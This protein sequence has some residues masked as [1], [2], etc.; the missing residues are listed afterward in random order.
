MARI[1]SIRLGGEY[2]GNFA[3]D[4][5]PVLL[6]GILR[7][8]LTGRLDVAFNSDEQN[9]VYFR[10]GVPIC[11]R[12]PDIGVSLADILI[13]AG[14]V[15]H[16]SGLSVQREAK[17]KHQSE[18]VV[19]AA[20]DLCPEG[21]LFSG[22][23]VRARSELVGLFNVGHRDFRFIEGKE[24]PASAEL[25]I[26]Q[27]L[28]LIYE[29]LLSSKD[30]SL[31]RDFL[32]SVQSR[33]FVLTDTYPG[34]VDAFE[35]GAELEKWVQTLT[36]ARGLA[37]LSTQGVPLDQVGVALMTL[38]LCG[39]L[40]IVEAAA[41]QASQLRLR[42][43][44]TSGEH[45]LP[46]P[47]ATLRPNS[48]MEPAAPISSTRLFGSGDFQEKIEPLIG[49]SYF[50]ILRIT[51]A[52]KPEQVERA[53]RFLTKHEHSE[54][55]GE[56]AL[57]QLA[58]D[59]AALLADPQRGPRYRECIEN[60]DESRKSRSARFQMEV[61]PKIDHAIVAISEG[62]LAEADIWITWAAKL[63]P[64]RSDLRLHRAFL[65]FCRAKPKHRPAVA[66]PLGEMLEA[67]I[68]K[69]PQNISLQAYLACVRAAL[70]DLNGIQS[71]MENGQV[72][73]H[74]LADLYQ[75]FVA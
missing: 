33:Q 27:S 57:A 64:E 72:R 44:A 60:A 4:P 24:I 63:D 41:E 66:K 22:M 58:Q 7:G 55:R 12:L 23:R 56:R 35:W 1:E 52:S 36:E 19:F 16:G 54:N 11:V 42:T 73:A 29:G 65:G 21:A 68:S 8:N 10:D 2:V 38:H 48:G 40:E 62:A 20:K 13:E 70:G 49:K 34:G 59:A 14:E 69:S 25:T 5:L 6:I 43:M 26:L 30:Q 32:R 75:R 45:V 28:P 50:E 39:M 61:G 51:L 46:G 31:V 67:A 53:I 3:N 47:Q 15:E 74:P 18:S 9:H 37:F 17:T 71:I